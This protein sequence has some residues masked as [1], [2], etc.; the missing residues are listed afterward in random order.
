MKKILIY[1]LVVLTLLFSACGK[2]QGTSQGN[3]T[4]KLNNVVE[5]TSEI[6]DYDF[7]DM[8]QKLVE[9]INKFSF[10]L[11]GEYLKEA[12]NNSVISPIS[13][14]MA[15]AMCYEV[16]NEENKPLLLEALD[17]TVEEV[18]QTR[19][20]VEAL[21][22]TVYYDKK[23]VSRLMLT[24]SIWFDNDNEFDYD[25]GI[26]DTLAK[27]YYC[28]AMQAPFQND[29]D[30]AN[31]LLKEFVK[32]KTKGLI[33]NDFDLDP[34]TLAV[35]VNTLYLKDMWDIEGFLNVEERLFNNIK[36]DFLIGKYYAGKVYEAK[37]YE[38]FY[39]YTYN[40]Y[41]VTFILP[42]DGSDLKDLMNAD[43]LNDA[44]TRKYETVNDKLEEK[45]LTRVIFP[46][47]TAE[48]DVDFKSI[49]ANKFGLGCLFDEFVSPLVDTRVYFSGVNH[50]AIL[51][52]DETGIEGAA[53]TYMPM[54]TKGLDPYKEV[55][56]DFVLDHDF[57][58]VISTESNIVL[59]TGVVTK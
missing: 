16:L 50:K 13:V 8:N 18:R 10:N 59:F 25:K 56:F 22:S 7:V 24:N 14:Y 43:V 27:D 4:L 20:L 58:F 57:G 41:K 23:E 26:L 19:A 52:V 53:V 21:T 9:K 5:P 47:F 46:K 35:I 55:Y 37:G 12:K 51:K 31:K 29:T 54:A 48:G 30:K 3:N 39:T 44:L 32:E 42:T 45:Y 33:D 34:N 17:L 6:S 2:T 28:H 15:L 40:G 36:H 1:L 38:A 11:T 49:L